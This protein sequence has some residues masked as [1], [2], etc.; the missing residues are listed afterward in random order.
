MGLTKAIRVIR[1]NLSD[2]S[3]EATDYWPQGVLAVQQP[4]FNQ[5]PDD[6]PWPDYIC[7]YFRCPTCHR[8]FEF[9]VE[10]YHGSGG[11]WKPIHEE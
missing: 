1:G 6:G 8:I 7:Y 2:K 3:I 4:T 5:L 9:S 10:T 11:H